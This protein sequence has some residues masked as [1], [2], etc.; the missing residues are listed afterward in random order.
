MSSFDR[1]DPMAEP[2]F[3]TAMDHTQVDNGADLCCHWPLFLTP[4]FLSS[5][6]NELPIPQEY[7]DLQKQLSD[8]LRQVGHIPVEKITMRPC[9]HAHILA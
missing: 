2:A 5:S 9:A 6:S 3:V 4:A 7:L 1:T 8:A